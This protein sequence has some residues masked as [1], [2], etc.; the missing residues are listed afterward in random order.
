M[1]FKVFRFPKELKNPILVLQVVIAGPR[2]TRRPLGLPPAARLP[3]A[4]RRE[5]RHAQQR[6][7]GHL[8]RR[9]EDQAEVV[10]PP[11]TRRMVQLYMFYCIQ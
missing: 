6:P 4:L 11:G 9:H 1:I 7:L 8:R 5:R 2:T 10:D 3:R